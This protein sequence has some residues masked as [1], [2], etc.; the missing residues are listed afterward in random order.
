MIRCSFLIFVTLLF[1]PT[2][3]IAAD[4]KASVTLQRGQIISAED[5]DITAKNA[6]LKE[7][8]I[9]KEMRRTIYAGSKLN[10]SL[11]TEPILIRRNA[12]VNMFYRFGRLEITASGRALD[13]GSA[14]DMIPLMNL[15]S[16]QRVQGRIRPDG[17][18][19]VGQ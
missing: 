4:I 3:A 13:S 18:V 8:Y 15:D 2:Q 6:D 7:T 14:G 5:L 19:E 12:R 10:P 9:G 1:V 16:R 17:N 11:V